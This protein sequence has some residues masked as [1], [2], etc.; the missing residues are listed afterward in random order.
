[1]TSTPFAFVSLLTSD[2][3]LPG[4]LA[5]AAALK[6]VHANL[7]ESKDTPAYETACIVT[8]ETL[9][10]STIKLL[11]R[12]FNVVIGVEVISQEDDKG[13]TLLGRPD[14]NTVITKIHVFRLTQYSK[15]IF[16]DADILPI[17]PLSHLFT[18]PHEFSAVPDVGWPDIFNSGMMVLS[19]GDDHYNNIQELLKTRGSWDG[20]DQGLL[21][22]WRGGDW[23]RLSFTYNTTP[24]AAYTYAP[25]YERFGSN[26]SAIHFIGTN[27]P[28]NSIAYRAP[29]ATNVNTPQAYDYSS[30]V[31][32]WY[33]VY[34]RHYR[35][36]TIA[37]DTDFEVRRYVSA[38]NEQGASGAEVL[39]TT[40][41]PVGGA[42]GLDDLRR[43]AVQGMSSWSLLQTDRASGEGEYRSM[44]IDGRIDLMR[45]KTAEQTKTLDMAVP[46]EPEQNP[47]VPA[48]PDSGPSTPIASKAKLPTESP[49]RW[50]TLPTP[51]PN[52]LPPAPH[53]R[54]LSLPPTPLHYVPAPYKPVTPE[55]V[56][57]TPGG[58][59]HRVERPR[60][61]S[62]PLVSWNPALEPPPTATPS[63]SFPMDNYFMNAW[64]QSPTRASDRPH[65]T[66]LTSP[67]SQHSL[68]RP[69]PQPEIPESLVREGHYRHV[70][71][72][73]SDETAASPSPDRTKVKRIFPW[74]GRP[75]QIPGRVFP[76]NESPP[77]GA[78]FLR[79]APPPEAPTTPERKGRAG[80]TIPVMPSPLMGFPPSLTYANAWDNV[81]SIQKYA[82]RLVRPPQAQPLGP[83]F[84]DTSDGGKRGSRAWSDKAEASSQDG[85]VEDEVDS[86]SDN[87]TSKGRSRSAS[88][89]SRA[90]RVKYRS[91]GIQTVP[92][93]RR[94]QSTQVDPLPVVAVTNADATTKQQRVRTVSVTRRQW[95]PSTGS[96]LL[97][98][99]MA[100][101]V[102]FGGDPSE[103]DS[104]AALTG[105]PT[106]LLSPR[107]ASSPPASSPSRASAPTIVTTPRAK[108]LATSTPSPS[109]RQGSNEASPLSSAG[110]VSPP[111]GEP[112]AS[113]SSVGS[114]RKAGRVWD[115][116]RGVEVFKRS[117][118]EVLAKFL[119]MGSWEDSATRA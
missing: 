106:R 79:S 110:P 13:L 41:V 78:V 45:P 88:L 33:S 62:P 35:S 87:E 95:P 8:P 16:L 39:D 63:T 69:P 7:Q 112:F 114:G 94:D 25:A 36:H 113:P 38:W 96:N 117:S 109:D 82:S 97:P 51:G 21:N 3:Y 89:S 48:Q 20:G 104:P 4:A 93:V 118:E 24:T 103:M 105:S 49:V 60:P 80:L 57:E 56:G 17:R 50:T 5:L 1:M 19:P 55:I 10:V 98:P 65:H 92:K 90:K 108:A 6:D 101:D 22:E 32:K 37:P 15:V 99:I 59:L 64:D 42:L 12:A 81:P 115:P 14:L 54:M 61:A 67:P 46:K 58:T 68:F 43:L 34:D 75:R 107:A 116:A 23:N 119:K 85:D 91:T 70:T 111:E 72:P 66:N 47:Q 74:E 84:E 102:V 73:G 40:V 77:P 27:K 9:D 83:A 44:P 30:L 31:D 53:V 2:S 86:D 28:W 11:R 52:E 26:I 29:G 18:L 71:G 100:E 76:E